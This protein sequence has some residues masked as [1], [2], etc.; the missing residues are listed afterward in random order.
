MPESLDAP[1]NIVIVTFEGF[2]E[3]DSFVALN[4]L[5]RVEHDD[6]RADIIAPNDQATSMNSVTIHT[7]KTFSTVN[8][9]DVVLFGSGRLTRSII[10]DEALMSY[11]QL[12]PSRQLIG[13]QC[14]GALILKRLGLVE[15]VPI[16]TDDSTQNYLSETD[17]Q[18]LAQPFTAHGNIATAGG[19]LSAQYLAAWVIYRKLGKQAVI[20]ALSYIA[21]VG[22]QQNFIQHTL[23]I[24]ET[25]INN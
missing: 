3:I 16:C 9:A 5:N 15:G 10:Q 22:E 21:P 25:G 13:S 2:N 11:F 12:E 17:I 18:I 4:L 24:V 23:E 1:V 7:Q 20:D 19:C 14:S 8:Q 6:W